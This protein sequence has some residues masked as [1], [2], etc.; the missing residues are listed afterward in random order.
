MVLA[1]ST[2]RR[3]ATRE[4][5]HEYRSINVLLLGKNEG[6]SACIRM[7]L[8]RSG[9][10]CWSAR[11]PEEALA[12]RVGQKHDPIHGYKCF[13]VPGGRDGEFLAVIDQIIHD[14]EL[15][16]MEYGGAG[17][18]HRLSLSC[19]PVWLQS[20]FFEFQVPNPFTC[21]Y[22]DRQSTVEV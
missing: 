3:V 10:P 1:G 19:N 17:F 16:S 11:S 7:Q 9:C 21:S 4:H 8:E 22:Q 14:R 18:R 5:C 6:G 2:R 15:A 20:A 12:L 13:G